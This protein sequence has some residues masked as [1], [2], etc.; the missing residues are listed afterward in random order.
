[1]VDHM[2]NVGLEGKEDAFSNSEGNEATV[3][4]IHVAQ[5][6]TYLRLAGLRHGFFM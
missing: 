5:V 2:K 6:L 1:M 4:P 3:L